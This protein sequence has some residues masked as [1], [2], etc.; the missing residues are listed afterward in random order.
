MVP[1]D[2]CVQRC[3]SGRRVRGTRCVVDD[4]VVQWVTSVVVVTVEVKVVEMARVA[5]VVGVT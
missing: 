2:F 5:V 3:G 4:P 1:V